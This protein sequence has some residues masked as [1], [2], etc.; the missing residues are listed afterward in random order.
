MSLSQFL[1]CLVPICLNIYYTTCLLEFQQEMLCGRKQISLRNQAPSN[2]SPGSQ[3]PD[4]ATELVFAE[5]TPST[6][7]DRDSEQTAIRASNFQQTLN[8]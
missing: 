5:L 2:L 6:D 8:N 4:H 1:I 7:T 3:I